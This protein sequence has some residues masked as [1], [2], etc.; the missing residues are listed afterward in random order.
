MRLLIR[1]GV[2][3]DVETI[4]NSMHDPDAAG[5]FGAAVD[6]T[7]ELLL[8]HPLIG[9]IRSFSAAGLRSFGVLGFNRY[10]VFYKVR[11]DGLEVFGVFD[12]VR[13]LPAVLRRR[14]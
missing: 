8:S 12:G 14:G 13:D 2:F 6:S 3:D 9:R 1:D 4:R 11:A 7:F 10:I 5:R